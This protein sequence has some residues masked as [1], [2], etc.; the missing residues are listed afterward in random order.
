MEERK[1]ANRLS[2]FDLRLS[3]AGEHVDERLVT[4]NEKTTVV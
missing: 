1:N 3:N 2:I 4:K